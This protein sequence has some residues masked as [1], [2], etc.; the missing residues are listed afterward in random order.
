MGLI[1]SLNWRYATKKF[2][3]SKRVSAKDINTLKESIRLAATS[4][5]LQPFKVKIV[6]DNS[7]KELLK[8]ESFNQS[9]ITDCSHVF[10]FSHLTQIT[11]DFI[12]N[13]IQLCA[14]ERNLALD[15]LTGYGNFMKTALGNLT[16]SEFHNWAS[17]QA[18]IGMANLLTACA[19]MRIDACPIEGFN[20]EKYN[21][22]LNLGEQNLSACVVVTVGYRSDDDSTQYLKKVRLSEGDLFL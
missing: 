9:Q 18:Y 22:I 12:D 8:N 14:D 3:V 2:D 5:G 7:I 16:A 21:E 17:K 13:Y 20:T 4:Y 6:E 19:E 10:V 1:E 11:D 15:K